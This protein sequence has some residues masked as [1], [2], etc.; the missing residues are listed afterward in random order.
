MGACD[1]VKS[2]YV[3]VCVWG[4]CIQRRMGVIW[5]IPD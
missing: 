5:F 3:W 4:F 2:G 1:Y